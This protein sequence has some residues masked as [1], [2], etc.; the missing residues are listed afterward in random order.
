MKNMMKV[1]LSLVLAILLFASEGY[2]FELAKT[3]EANPAQDLSGERSIRGA[4]ISLSANRLLKTSI[5]E[6]VLLS[7]S[8]VDDRRA[9]EDD[10]SQVVITLQGDT[11][12]RVVIY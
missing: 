7:L 10:L 11:V 6:Y 5:G 2:A 12:T 9:S 4:F 3:S 8:V 1:N